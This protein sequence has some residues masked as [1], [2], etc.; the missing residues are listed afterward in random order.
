MKPSNRSH[1]HSSPDELDSDAVLESMWNKRFE[2]YEWD[3]DD[4]AE[5]DDDYDER[6]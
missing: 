4:G 2:R 6:W 3:D 5:D 1:R